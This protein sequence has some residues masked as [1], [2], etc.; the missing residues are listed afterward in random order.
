MVDMPLNGLMTIGIDISHDTRDR[1]KTFSALV[2]TMDLKTFQTFFSAV[3]AHTKGE[4]MSNELVFNVA[5]ALRQYESIHKELPKRICIYR[6]GV[7]EG[8]MKYVYEHEVMQLKAKLESIYESN[9]SEHPLK[10]CFIVVSRK[11]NT[12]LFTVNQKNPLPGTVV[13]DVITLPERLVFIIV[14]IFYIYK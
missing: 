13:D 5:K 11:T 4:G 2:A 10:M 1:S 8:E 14:Y 9:K 3:S 12:R 6:D 7:G